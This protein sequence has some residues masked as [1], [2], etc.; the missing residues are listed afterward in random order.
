MC[1]W[2]LL[3]ISWN[4]ACALKFWE[5][6]SVSP[7]VCVCCL[8]SRPPIWRSP[9]CPTPTVNTNSTSWYGSRTQ[10][11]SPFLSGPYTQFP[12]YII[13]W[14]CML[15]LYLS[16]TMIMMYTRSRICLA[17]VT[18]IF[19][20]PS[21]FLKCCSVRVYIEYRSLSIPVRCV[22]SDKCWLPLRVL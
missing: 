6:V 18:S 8:E 21:G 2:S 1:S 7:P 22:F 19:G 4:P 12:W 20:R 9:D 17:R 13:L 14:K 11:L 15:I 3:W 10:I 16:W 5:N